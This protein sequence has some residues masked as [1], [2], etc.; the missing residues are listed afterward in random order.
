MGKRGGVRNSETRRS[1]PESPCQV[2]HVGQVVGKRGGVRNSE[3]S[4]WRFRR[5]HRKLDRTPVERLTNPT[6][7]HR[8]LAITRTTHSQSGKIPRPEPIRLRW[9]AGGRLREAV[10]GCRGAVGGWWE[11]VGGRGTANMLHRHAFRQTT[12]FVSGKR[13]FSTL[14]PS[15]IQLRNAREAARGGRPRCTRRKQ[16]HLGR[17]ARCCRTL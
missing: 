6:R 10:G 4:D 9:E 5:L 14:P 2:R 16:P 17:A 11:A 7:A 1:R 8:P 3:T 12:L 13:G 15:S